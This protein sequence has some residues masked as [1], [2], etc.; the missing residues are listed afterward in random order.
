[1]NHRW[2]RHLSVAVMIVAI[3]VYACAQ[4]SGDIRWTW[5]GAVT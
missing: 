3:A 2:I 5:S 1:M 4:P